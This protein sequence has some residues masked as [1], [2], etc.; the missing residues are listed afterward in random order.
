[1]KLEELEKC[2]VSYNNGLGIKYFQNNCFCIYYQKVINS[3]VTKTESV[4]LLMTTQMSIP[5]RYLCKSSI[6]NITFK[7]SI[8][9]VNPN[10]SV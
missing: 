6:T 4:L 2:I 8:T 1:M 3:S 9:S 10:V 5:S 7:W